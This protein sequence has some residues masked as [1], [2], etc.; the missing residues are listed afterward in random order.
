MVRSIPVELRLQTGYIDLGC[1]RTARLGVSGA[2]DLAS[3]DGE[4]ADGRGRAS[5][6]LPKSYYD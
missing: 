6:P 2:A 5:R 4:F 1:G 3:T